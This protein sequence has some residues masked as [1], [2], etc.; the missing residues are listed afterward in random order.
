MLAIIP[1]YVITMFEG[2]KNELSNLFS[3]KIIFFISIFN[4]TNYKV[5][6]CYR[7]FNLNRN[8]YSTVVVSI[9]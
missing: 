4:S 6:K 8:L 7:T 9:I 5:T 2:E 3:S 1:I